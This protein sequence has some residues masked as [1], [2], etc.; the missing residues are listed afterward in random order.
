VSARPV[1]V[2]DLRA[3][4]EQSDWKHRVPFGHALNDPVLGPLLAL[5]A[6][7]LTQ[8]P[9]PLDRKRLAAGESP[10]DFE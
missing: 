9:P 5:G 1:T 7:I 4:Y 6:R 3:V 10:K 8:P 2:E